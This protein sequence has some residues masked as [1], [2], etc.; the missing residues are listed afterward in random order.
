[1]E[2]ETVTGCLR[3]FGGHARCRLLGDHDGAHDFHHAFVPDSD[4]YR[5]SICKCGQSIEAPDHQ[6]PNAPLSRKP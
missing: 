1:M 6:Q 4:R 2:E 5:T 3:W